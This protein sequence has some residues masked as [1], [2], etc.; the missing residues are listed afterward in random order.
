MLL[1]LHPTFS[2]F[3][4]KKKAKQ[5]KLNDLDINMFIF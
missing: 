4:G 5:V 2:S 1:P 3:Y